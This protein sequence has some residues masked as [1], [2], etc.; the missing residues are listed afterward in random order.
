MKKLLYPTREERLEQDVLIEER[1]HSSSDVIDD[2]P[3]DFYMTRVFSGIANKPKVIEKPTSKQYI[4]IRVLNRDMYDKVKN[5]LDKYE[6]NVEPNE[7]LTNYLKRH[8]YPSREER[9]EQDIKID[10]IDYRSPDFELLKT[11][12]DWYLGRTYSFDASTNF[13]EGW[14]IKILNENIRLKVEDFLLSFKEKYYKDIKKTSMSYPL[15]NLKPLKDY[16]MRHLYPT[17][18]ERLEQ[19]VI[20]SKDYQSRND[21]DY[22][23]SY[24]TRGFGEMY[25][26][27]Q[28]FYLPYCVKILN[29]NRR[30]DIMRIGSKVRDFCIS[31][32]FPG[33]TTLSLHVLKDFYIDN[34]Y[35]QDSSDF[36]DYEYPEIKKPVKVEREYHPKPLFEIEYIETPI[37]RIK[38]IKEYK[39]LALF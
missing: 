19:D 13:I 9:L 32:K 8:L 21:W 10:L 30:E 7:R 24:H 1:G 12:Y 3:Y 22:F 27:F 28:A 14:G 31:E 25:D 17:R 38:E 37:K 15:L 20:I 26:T 6:T 35:P 23:I 33:N 18:E 5:A 36:L 4:G 16:L 29:E 34:L 2:T 11:K 39:T